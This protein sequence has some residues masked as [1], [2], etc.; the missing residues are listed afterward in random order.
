MAP[1]NN[2]PK[3]RPTSTHLSSIILPTNNPIKPNA[4]TM[5]TDIQILAS[6]LNTLKNTSKKPIIAPIMNAGLKNDCFILPITTVPLKWTNR[7]LN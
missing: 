6:R 3:N 2:D 1:P 7:S 4:Q 5:A